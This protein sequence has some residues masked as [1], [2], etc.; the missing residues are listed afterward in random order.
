[1]K[2]TKEQIEQMKELEKEKSI[3]EISV[4]MGIPISTIRYW[5]RD[6]ERKKI[7]NNAKKW[8]KKQPKE[9]RKELNERRKEYRRNYYRQKYENDEEYRKRRIEYSKKFNKKI[10]TGNNR[11]K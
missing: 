9:K 7:I 6:E 8:Y 11:E 3:K 4:I 2:I 5:L 10:S 1:M